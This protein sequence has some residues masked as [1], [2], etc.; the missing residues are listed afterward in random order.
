MQL[1]IAKCSTES[2]LGEVDSKIDQQH[3]SI[4]F[5]KDM[6]KAL[7]IELCIPKRKLR[8]S[9][10]WCCKVAAPHRGAQDWTLTPFLVRPVVERECTFA[11]VRPWSCALCIEHHCWGLRSKAA[12]TF[13]SAAYNIAR[14]RKLC[15]KVGS[16]VVFHPLVFALD[17]PM[18]LFYYLC[19]MLILY[20]VPWLDVQCTL[21]IRDQVFGHRVSSW[22][23]YC[24][25]SMD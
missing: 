23:K 17:C 15:C 1:C 7:V 2:S 14:W 4:A 18:C 20:L 19:S 11:H 22:E 5:N 16:I 24:T 21:C 12:P 10:A 3:I 6:P 9:G 13:C 25:L 8:P